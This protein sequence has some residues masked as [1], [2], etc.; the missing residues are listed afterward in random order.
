MSAPTK[1][2]ENMTKHLTAVEIEARQAAETATLPDR[3]EVKLRPPSYLRRDKAAGKYWRQAL[4]RMEGLSLLDVLDTETLAIYCTM[5][6][7]RDSLSALCRSVL[8][9]AEE[10]EIGRAHV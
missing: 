1:P 6:S 4:K 7:R 10:K 9:Q 2:L 3:P 8:D 5:L